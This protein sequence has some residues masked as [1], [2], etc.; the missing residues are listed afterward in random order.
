MSQGNM[1]KFIPVEASKWG[2]MVQ[3][4]TRVKELEEALAKVKAERDQLK[5]D[6]EKSDGVVWTLSVENDRLKQSL[7]LQIEQNAL[8]Q[9]GFKM[10]QDNVDSGGLHKDR[11]DAIAR[12]EVEN[13]RL[14]AEVERLT[15]AG[16]ELEKRYFEYATPDDA[17]KAWHAAKGV[18]S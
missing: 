5:A 12:L 8:A 11:K 16:D 2:E 17:V 15:K 18:Q 3:A 1:M 14:K 6:L 10:Y 7:R 9:V 13:A 4:M